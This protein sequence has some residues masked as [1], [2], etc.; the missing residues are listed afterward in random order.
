MMWSLLTEFLKEFFKVSLFGQIP[1][2]TGQETLEI[3]KYWKIC[4]VIIC[5]TLP[6]VI[7]NLLSIIV[8]LFRYLLLKNCY[9]IHFTLSYWNITYVFSEMIS[10]IVGKETIYAM[11]QFKDLH[12]KLYGYQLKYFTVFIHRSC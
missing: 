1:I 8:Q 5:S 4:N 12:I 6:F 7:W 2:S 10:K 3:W 9:E 11:W